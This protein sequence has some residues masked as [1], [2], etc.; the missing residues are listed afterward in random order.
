MRTWPPVRSE[1][2]AACASMLPEADAAVKCHNE[3]EASLKALQDERVAQSQQL[4]SRVDDLK[5]HEAKHADHESNLGKASIEQAAD[6]E[7]LQA[8]GHGVAAAK[9]A[10]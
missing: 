7:H 1:A 2:K 5:A 10:M 9:V 8:L 6:R 3:A 4:Q